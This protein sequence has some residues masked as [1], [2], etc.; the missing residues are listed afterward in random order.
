M[1]I[2]AF[3]PFPLVGTLSADNQLL[4]ISH[5]RDVTFF[6]NIRFLALGTKQQ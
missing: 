6:Q 5:T 2:A 1:F 4:I 3:G